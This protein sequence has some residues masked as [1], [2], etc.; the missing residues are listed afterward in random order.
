MPRAKTKGKSA[1]VAKEPSADVPPPDFVLT[2]PVTKR[3]KEGERCCPKCGD[4]FPIG[5]LDDHL[6]TAHQ[7]KKRKRAATVP[8]R[9]V[10]E[11]T[12]PPGPDAGALSPDL[13]L[14]VPVSKKPKEGE[15]C[16]PKCGEPFPI[17]D[18]EDHLASV[19]RSGKKD[20]A[21]DTVTEP[22]VLEC[23]LCPYRGKN[24]DRLT[25]HLL[26]AH[27]LGNTFDCTMCDEVFTKRVKLIA[28]MSYEHGLDKSFKCGECDAVYASYEGL[29]SHRKMKHSK[30]V[31][32]TTALDKLSW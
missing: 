19:H 24:K 23:S 9:T 29:F 17:G 3:P 1:I 18:L 12:E 16:C 31:R 7:S 22:T 28:H 5:E 27:R 30:E 8:E 14:T 11:S 4:P 20:G 32:L 26:L 13:V 15:K 25:R 2:V 10:P 21:G 6:A